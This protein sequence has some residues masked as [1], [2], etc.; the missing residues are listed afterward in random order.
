MSI[1][2]SVPVIGKYDIIHKTG[3]AKH[4]ALSSEEF[5]TTAPGYTCRKFLKFGRLLRC[6]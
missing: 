3:S 2:S 6:T 1:Y 4:I 5:R